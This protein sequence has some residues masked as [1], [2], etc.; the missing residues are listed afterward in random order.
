MINV[1]SSQDAA[2][3]VAISPDGGT[4]FTANGDGAGPHRVTIV[5]MATGLAGKSITVG[6]PPLKL[7]VTPDGR[8]LYALIMSMTGSRSAQVTPISLGTA[9]AGKPTR[10]PDGAI[11]MVTSPDGTRVYVLAYTG[12]NAMAVIPV[13]VASGRQGSRFEVPADSQVLAISPDGRTVYIGTFDPHHHQADEVI[14][15]DTKLAKTRARIAVPA[16]VSGLAVSQDGQS[17]Y[18]LVHDTY[19]DDAGCSEGPCSLIAID[20]ASRTAGDPVAL[21]TGCLQ[22]AATGEGKF[23]YVLNAHEIITP[24]EVAAGYVDAP[25]H[26]GGPSDT[27]DYDFAIA[28]DG[29]TAYVGDRSQGVAVIPLVP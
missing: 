25:I 14:A 22:I 7:T 4:L 20:T 29:H 15:F 9:Q 27:G 23:V 10:F 28:P 1:G 3:T 18:A 24:V 5:N 16:G 26:A 6:G 11:D 21:S 12:K 17:L 13:S 8:T 19:C 2:D